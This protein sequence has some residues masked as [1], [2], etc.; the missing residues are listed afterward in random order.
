[1]SEAS[2]STL[3]VAKLKAL[4]VL[5]D[6]PTSGRKADLVERLLEADVDRSML[7]LQP[8]NAADGSLSDKAS[9]GVLEPPEDADDI[10]SEVMF[11]LEDDDTLTPVSADRSDKNDPGVAA[12]SIEAEP[13][14]GEV[15]EAEL[16]PEGSPTPS[17]PT[18]AASVELPVSKPSVPVP[19]SS[20]TGSP[21][22]LADM[23]RK[24]QF[25]AVALTVLV[26]GAGGWYYLNNQ[27]EPFTADALR[28]GDSMRYTVT[29]GEFMASEEYV[30]LVTEQFDDLSD[31]CKMRLLFAGTGSVSITEGT[32]GDLLSQPTEDRLGA[33]S[34]RGGQGQSWLTVETVNEMS[35]SKFNIYG[36]TS[37][38][39]IGGGTYCPDFAEGTEGR[40]DLTVTRWNE[41]REQSTLA[42]HLD[43]S[44]QNTQGTYEADAM[45]YGVGGL[46]GGLED[47]SPGLGMVLQP[48]EL[49]DFFGN[50]YITDDATGTSS[51]WAWRVIG[52]EMLGNTEVWK[53][54]AS[55]RDVQDFCL[56]FATMNM[57]LEAD[58]PW[59][60]RQTV[61][62]SI[63]SN[64]ANQN[65]CSGW[66]ER[67]VE[68]VLPEGELELHHTF[69]RTSTTRGVKSIELGMAYNNRPQANE[70]NPSDSDL[71]A[72]GANGLHLPDNSSLR[73]HPLDVAINCIDEFG[74]AASG[75][76]AALDDGGYIWRAQNEL[77]GSAT[78]WNVSWVATDSSAGWLLFSISGEVNE[79]LNCEYISR[80]AYDE[81]VTHN[82]DSI[83][84][85]LPLHDMVE[86]LRVTQRF[87]QLTGDEALFT[88]SGLHETTRVGYLVVV[89][90]NG[91]GFDLSDLF[92]SV[93]GATTID[94]QR[95]WDEPTWSHTYSLLADGT[96]G[97]VLG[98]THVKQAR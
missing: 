71:A 29:E 62:V 30:E 31:Y 12:P 23:L 28:Y 88:S 76:N 94:V 25:V 53:V 20:K 78:E 43:A 49:A 18:V 91:L 67:G 90:G 73:T 79:D 58:S 33:V 32:P 83:P 64:E 74:S 11:S 84:D 27:L 15:L 36:H 14:E 22:T 69:E 47:L 39:S 5:N 95:S 38:P 8:L 82:R 72:W 65:S 54:T 16:F 41:L 44:L 93:T 92:D 98:W 9:S 35:L 4:C 42:T 26:L 24:P 13:L 46:L 37:S 68:A 1:M 52:T 21:T 59:V 10:T 89:P 48:V 87:P 86:R 63:S 6:L 55:H 19:V 81:S 60:V 50:T 17:T 40:A 34:A 2:A 51:G 75:A 56:G 70:L 97:R 45:T 57:W 85:A 96:D 80:G 3:T 77:N 66:L 61:D 7:G